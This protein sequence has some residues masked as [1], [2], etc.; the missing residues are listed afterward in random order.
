MDVE[1]DKDGQR[2]GEV[3]MAFEQTKHVIYS[4]KE[5]NMGI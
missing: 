1:K 3:F 5:A 2:N 4:N